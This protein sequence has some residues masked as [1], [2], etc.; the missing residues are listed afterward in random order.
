MKEFIGSMLQVPGPLGFHP[1]PGCNLFR[2]GGDV[3]FL[4]ETDMVA[5]HLVILQI[6]REFPPDGA[7]QFLFGAVVGLSVDESDASGVAS[8]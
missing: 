7:K 8:G 5:G 4:H 3:W 1:M 2:N 6:R